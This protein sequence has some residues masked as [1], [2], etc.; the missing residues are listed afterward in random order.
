MKNGLDTRPSPIVGQWYAADASRLAEEVDGYVE[1]A[2]MPEIRDEVV[3]V[4]APHAGYRY[5]G[6][7]AGYAFASLKGLTPEIVAVFSP[8]HQPYYGELFTTAHDAYQTPLGIIPVHQGALNALDANL[9]AELGF[10]LTRVAED[11]E[12]SLEI[13]LP[14][15]QRVLGGEFQLLPVMV[16]DQ[17]VR[18]AL[19]LGIA[20][21]ELFLDGGLFF[22]KSFI[23]VASTDLSHFHA[24]SEANQLDKKMLGA[25]ESFDPE[26][27]IR[28]EEKGEGFA[29]GRGAVA[30][31]LQASKILGADRARRLHYA[32]SGDI[33]G[34]YSNVV[35]Y[36]AAVVTRRAE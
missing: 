34:D 2:E 31:V 23:M 3:A 4:I 19:G 27:V 28:T 10:G 32:T 24:Q 1:A 15:L 11:G 6:A 18:T 35:G 33:R 21:A 12:H 30:A 9:K 22:K 13:E 16:R 36:G 14:F 26:L 8:M 29:C 7:V 20:L 25:I 17:S 5:S